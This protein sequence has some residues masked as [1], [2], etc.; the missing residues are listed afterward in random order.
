[1]TT[2]ANEQI[3]PADDDP[4]IAEIRAIRAAISAECDHDPWKL[5]ARMRTFEVQ[6]KHSLA[7]GDAA[8][9]GSSPHQG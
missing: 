9:Q 8:H 5:V 1:M 4:E 2:M 7:G 6:A 3:P